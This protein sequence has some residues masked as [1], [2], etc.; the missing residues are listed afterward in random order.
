M[1]PGARIEALIRLLDS[2]YTTGLPADVVVSKFYRSNKFIGS[3]DRKFL[4]QHFFHFF[5][6]KGRISGLFRLYHQHFTAYEEILAYFVYVEKKTTAMLQEYQQDSVH[7]F[8]KI[9]KDY[10]DFLEWVH[11]SKDFCFT[12]AERLNVPPFLWDAFKERFGEKMAEELEALNEEAP[13]DLR[14]N[15]LRI[16]I[17]DVLSKIDAD[18]QVQQCT[19]SPIGLRCVGRP[20]ISEHRFY[21]EGKIEIQDEASQIVG[22]LCEAHP[23]MQVLD[24]CAGAGGKSLALAAQMQNKGRLYACDISQARLEKSKER[25]RRAGVHNAT[26]HLLTEGDKW[27]KRHEGFFDLVLVDAPCTG[28]GTWRRNPDA[29]WRMTPQTIQELTRQQGDIL[30]MASKL[31][32]LGGRLVYSTCS[33]LPREDEEQIKQFLEHHPNYFLLPVGSLWQNAGIKQNYMGH[34]NYALFTP[35]TYETDGFFVVA[36]EKRSKI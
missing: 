31:L 20:H 17:E 3:A 30:H 2:F 28:T 27:L 22:L 35:K 8:K 15:T 25:F 14:V 18:F 29:R 1:T 11:V 21:K 34:P 13:L 12:E 23:G 36:L 24:L 33:L 5:R 32:R 9:P 4:T 10:L 7:S 19:Y 6:Q 16:P 26:C